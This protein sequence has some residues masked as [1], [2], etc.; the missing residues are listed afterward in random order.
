[1]LLRILNDFRMTL[2][3][4]FFSNDAHATVNVENITQDEASF[5]ITCISERQSEEPINIKV[6]DCILLKKYKIL[7]LVCRIVFRTM[8]QSLTIFAKSSILHVWQGSEYP[9]ANKI[10]LSSLKKKESTADF[11]QCFDF[12]VKLTVKPE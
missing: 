1:M 4:D 8:S 2:P 5:Y 10:G 7:Y 3:I 9:F 12:I 11:P 6:L